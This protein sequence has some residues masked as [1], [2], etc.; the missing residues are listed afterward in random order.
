M[1]P[2]L[3]FSVCMMIL[4]IRFF[5]RSVGSGLLS[6]VPVVM[7]PA[8]N[9]DGSASLFRSPLVCSAFQF[10]QRRPSVGRDAVCSLLSLWPDL[11][12]RFRRSPSVCVCLC[13]VGY[14]WLCSCL[15]CLFSVFYGAV[16]SSDAVRLVMVLC[17]VVGRF[18]RV[19]VVCCQCLRNGVIWPCRTFYT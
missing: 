17:G 19:V 3:F 13:L 2:D 9:A 14:V 8:D 6:L 7:L 15:H 12:R 5:R 18:R 16:C 1:R 11:F 10:R 4:S